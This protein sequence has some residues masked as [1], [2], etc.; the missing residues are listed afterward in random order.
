MIGEGY[1]LTPKHL[2]KLVDDHGR[3]ALVVTELGC[4]RRV[5]FQPFFL[6]FMST[7]MRGVRVKYSWV[8]V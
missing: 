3:V 5:D 7:R 1:A 2:E 8:R 4:R 6:L